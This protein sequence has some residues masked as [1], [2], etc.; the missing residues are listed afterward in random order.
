ML[1]ARNTRPASTD[2]VIIGAGPVGLL[3]ANLL[4]ARGISTQ[5][6]DQRE[7][8]LE[9][10]MAI[11]VTPPSMEILKRLGLDTVFQEAGVPVRHAEVHESH[12]RL[13][14]LDFAQIKSD[15]PFFLSIPQARTVQR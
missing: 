2:V 12:R 1:T 13:G 3:L 5:I 8:P 15:Y 7:Q 4:G 14:R 9:S 6:F 10:S 11:G